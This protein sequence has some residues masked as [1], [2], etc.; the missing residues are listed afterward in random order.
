LAQF[1]P[2]ESVAQMPTSRTKSPTKVDCKIYTTEW[3][4]SRKLAAEINSHF[5]WLFS[6]HLMLMTKLAKDLRL[7]SQKIIINPHQVGQK[8]LFKL[9]NLT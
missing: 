8:I 9:Y 5:H 1:D 2:I 3:E 6:W 4:I 7:F